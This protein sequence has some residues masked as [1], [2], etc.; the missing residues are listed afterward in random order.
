MHQF[1]VYRQ[2]IYSKDF[3]D[4]TYTALIDEGRE[5]LTAGS[6]CILD[7]TFSKKKHRNQAAD[8]AK[9]LNLPFFIVE[10]ICPENIIK[11]RLEKRLKGKSVSDARWELFYDQKKEFE[12][13]ENDEGTHIIV[14][15][16]KRLDENNLFSFNYL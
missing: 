10:C 5:I 15:T 3:T 8:L 1:E 12:P 13:I 7:A 4:K 14:D 16:S 2:G 11:K 6:S 9:E